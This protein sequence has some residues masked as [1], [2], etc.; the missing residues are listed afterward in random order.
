MRICRVNKTWIKGELAM[1]SLS[2]SCTC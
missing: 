2:T 1:W